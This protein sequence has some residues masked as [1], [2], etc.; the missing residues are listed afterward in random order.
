VGTARSLRELRTAGL[1]L[2]ATR[3]TR[4]RDEEPRT[5][6][7]SGERHQSPNARRLRMA[8]GTDGGVARNR[9]LV[10]GVGGKR[11]EVPG[12][13]RGQQ[14]CCNLDHIAGCLDHIAGCPQSLVLGCWPTIS[15]QLG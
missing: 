15:F 11:E 5:V 2:R 12:I 10:A 1:T 9:E 3:A 8:S 13:Y 7:V 4:Q 14:V 6:A